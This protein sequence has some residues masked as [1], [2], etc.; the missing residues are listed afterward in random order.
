MFCHRSPYAVGA[1]GERNPIEWRT[2][3][4]RVANA[5]RLDGVR[6]TMTFAQ[7]LP[8]KTTKKEATTLTAVASFLIYILVCIK[9]I[10]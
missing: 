9:L 2:Q 10:L 5:T 7:L 3:S 4:D 1:D 6:S 8:N